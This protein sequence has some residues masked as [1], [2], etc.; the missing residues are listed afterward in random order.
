MTAIM[1]LFLNTVTRNRSLTYEIKINTSMEDK[2]TCNEIKTKCFS[3]LKVV[4]RR[5]KN[6]NKGFVPLES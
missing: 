5:E 1:R 3:S 4:S 6:K 2:G